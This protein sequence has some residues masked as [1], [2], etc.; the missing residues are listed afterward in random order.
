AVEPSSKRPELQSL[1]LA[2][3]RGPEFLS[4]RTLANRL[5][6]TSGRGGRITH[7]FIE[8]VTVPGHGVAISCDGAAPFTQL[9]IRRIGRE[10]LHDAVR[11]TPPVDLDARRRDDR[12]YLLARH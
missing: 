3:A 11:G 7:R 8:R 10:Q 9:L 5:G 6:R 4:E 1:R 2:D 12:R